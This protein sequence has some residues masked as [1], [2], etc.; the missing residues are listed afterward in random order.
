MIVLLFK[1]LIMIKYFILLFI[2]TSANNLDFCT[3]ING[4]V[5]KRGLLN[6]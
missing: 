1:F 2:E 5:Y 4:S 6:D 3:K